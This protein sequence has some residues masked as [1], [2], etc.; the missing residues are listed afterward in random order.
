[1]MLGKMVIQLK[2]NK[3]RPLLHITD[4]NVSHKWNFL[5]K[6]K[7]NNRKIGEAILTVR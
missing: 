7:I 4:K 3:G 5:R 6:M 2:E 1:M